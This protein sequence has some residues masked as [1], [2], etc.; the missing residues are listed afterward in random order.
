MADPLHEDT[1]ARVAQHV[2]AGTVASAW[3]GDAP[4]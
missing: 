4:V 1:A 2:H 3:P